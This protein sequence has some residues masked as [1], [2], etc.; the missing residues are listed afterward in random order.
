MS[1]SGTVS[2][3]NNNTISNLGESVA[4]NNN[5]ENDNETKANNSLKVGNMVL[6]PKTQN[7]TTKHRARILSFDSSSDNVEL[8]FLNS[9]SSSSKLWG[10][11]WSS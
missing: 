10:E 5:F 7:S 8:E 2:N 1:T 9:S 4:S 11:I 3:G 6:A